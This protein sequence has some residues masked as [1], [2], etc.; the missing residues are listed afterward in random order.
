MIAREDERSREPTVD[1]VAGLVQELREILKT[2]TILTPW[3]EGYE[4]SIKRWSDGVEKKA[5]RAFTKEQ[6]KC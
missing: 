1:A 5:V 6:V 3:S 4:E 2:S